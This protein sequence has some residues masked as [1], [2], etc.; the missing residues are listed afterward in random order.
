MASM[1]G[2]KVPWN[3]R[4]R[5]K[6]RQASAIGVHLFCG[7]DRSTWKSSAEAVCVVTV[8]QAEDIMADDTYA[9]L[10]DLA[11]TGKVKTV[12]GG[13]PCRTFSAL[14]AFR[15]GGGG[16]R[17]L[18]DR[19]GDGRWG[20]Q[21]LGE[22]ETWRVRQDSIMIFRMIFLWMVAAAAARAHPEDPM[23]FGKASTWALPEHQE[24]TSLWVFPEVKFLVKELGWFWWQ[25]DQGPLGHPRRK[26]TRILASTPWPR[27]LQN[28]RG[29][30]ML[31]EEERDHDGS[32]FRSATWAA[33]A[34]QLKQ[35]IKSEVEASLAGATLERVMKMDQGFLEHLQ[36]DH[37]PYRRDC[38]ACLAVSFR[39]HIHRRIVAPNAWCLSLDV[40]GPARQGDDEVL[41]RVKYGLIAT[42]AVPDV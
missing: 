4:Q 42:L 5:K 11:L 27:E 3:R 37:I 24:L 38:R 33:W 16:P 29:P 12:F 10:L 30:S 41:K 23:E 26:P 36:R 31:Q 19:E 6:W 1:A 18:R 39:G 20:R 22:W 21:G 17:P 2:A 14:R 7:S 32:G 40:I 13:P 15:P 35:V 8:D 34:P 9:A 25:F 28:V